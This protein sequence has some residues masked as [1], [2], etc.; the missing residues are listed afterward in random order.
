MALTVI[1][2]E[3]LVVLPDGSPAATYQ[4]KFDLTDEDKDSALIL[5]EPI[6]YTIPTDGNISVDLWPNTRGYTGG[7]YN[8]F[9]IAPGYSDP[10]QPAFTISIP[11]VVGPV[12]IWDIANLVAPPT[13]SD[14][15]AAEDAA[16][17]YAA[18]AAISA[19][20]A[21]AAGKT[22]IQEEGTE[23]TDNPAFLNF[24]GEGVTAE[25]NGSGV[26]VTIVGDVPSTTPY[27]IVI[28]GQSNAAGANNGGPNP[29]NALVKTWDGGTGDWGGSDYTAL[30]WTQINPHG[31]QGNNNYALARAH[32]IADD[33]GRPVYIVYD[34]QGGT[35]IDEW[36]LTGTASARYAAIKAK[37][38]LALASTELSGV[39]TIDE[40]IWSQGEEDYLSDYDVYL[41]KLTTLMTQFRAEAW[42][43][44]ETPIYIT[45]PSELHYRYPPVQS[46]KF[47]AYAIDSYTIFVPA[48][49]MDTSDVTHFTGEHLWQMGY[50]RIEDATLTEVPGALFYN[51]GDG[52]AV[53]TDPTVLATFSS[54]VSFDSWTQTTPPNGPNATGSISWGFECNADGNYTYCLGYQNVTDNGSTYT[55]LLGRLL[56]SGSGGDYCGAF[57]YQNVMNATYGFAA[58]RGHTLADSGGAAVGLFSEY[59]TAE[60]DAVIFQ[61]GIGTSS[62]N[63]KNGLTVRKSGIVEMKNLPVYADEAAAVT[64]GLLQGQVYRTATGELR[65]KL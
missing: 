40:I 12:N 16:Q 13:K 4:L 57:G 42:V 22:P 18:A 3:G 36:T 54:L 6:Y 10:L 33:T 47:H 7:V 55:A 61:A 32:R 9:L 63:R 28:S 23:V 25:P 39:T 51:R 50:Y 48:N 24:I 21:V 34:A 1:T 5:H 44:D 11:D 65:I 58:G 35:G 64:A 37:V 56:S 46:M 14:A 26:D 60:G 27:V 52:V 15:Q 19:G 8:V 41:T 30:P 38:E 59:T 17:G 31:N 53:P 20:E 45:A 29:A 62:S 49:G 43:N 2:V